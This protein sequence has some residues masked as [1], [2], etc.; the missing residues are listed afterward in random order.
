ME[1]KTAY[2]LSKLSDSDIKST[3]E[4]AEATMEYFGRIDSPYLIMLVSRHAMIFR[5]SL[6]DD[7]NWIVHL[8]FRASLFLTQASC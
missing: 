7:F 6:W 3:T 2:F 8:N 1:D 5:V 4:L